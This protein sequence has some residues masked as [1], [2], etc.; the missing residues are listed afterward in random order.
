MNKKLLY[1]LA[2]LIKGWEVSL[3]LILPILQTQ[4]KINVYMLGILAAAFACFQIIASLSAGHLAEKF[5]SKTIIVGAMFLYSLSWLIL[6]FPVNILVLFGVYCLAGAGSGVFI[7]LANSAVAKSGDKVSAKELGDFSAFTDVGRVILSS[8]TAFLIGSIGLSLASLCFMVLAIASIIIVV[9][10]TIVRSVVEDQS[11][12]VQYIKSHHLLE[13]NKFVL[14]VSAGVFD[15]FASSSVY[16]FIPLLLIPKGI[17]LSSVGLLSALF[18][19]GYIFGRMTLGRLADK[20][21]AVKILVISEISMAILIICLIFI[22]NFILIAS[23]LFVLGIF[24]RGTS[25]VI[26]AI[27]AHSVGEKEKFDKAF[28]IHSFSL[29]ISNVASRSVYGF[30]A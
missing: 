10:M 4:G 8:L 15:I 24:T 12:E 30:T 19:V 20:Y 28:S 25:P 18:F 3:L 27:M 16:I 29:N 13:S 9:K 5:N 1:A 21:D 17:S 23:V 14:A 26:R 22:N 11:T 2:F 7:P 6:F